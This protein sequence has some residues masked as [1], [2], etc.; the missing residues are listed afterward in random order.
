ML[1][2]VHINVTIFLN[3]LKK[4]TNNISH[5]NWSKLHNPEPYNKFDLLVLY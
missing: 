2:D 1:I 5:E 4:K 3:L